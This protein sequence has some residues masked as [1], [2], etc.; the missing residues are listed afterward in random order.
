MCVG[1]SECIVAMFDLFA[2]QSPPQEVAE[3]LFSG[4]GDS[5]A[6]EAVARLYRVLTISDPRYDIKSLHVI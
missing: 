3:H 5:R 4:L 6:A 2:G 1:F